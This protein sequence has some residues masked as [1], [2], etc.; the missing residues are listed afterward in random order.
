MADNF[1]F[2]QFLTENKLGAYSKLKEED[3]IEEAENIP[4]KIEV[5]KDGYYFAEDSLYDGE[6]YTEEELRH[7]LAHLFVKGDIWERSSEDPDVF[8]CIEG[9][10]KGEPSEGWW[11]YE[12]AKKFIKPIE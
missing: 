6:Y 8:I 10:W 3:K 11:D 5:I 4:S 1:N 9:S 2:K 7:G 12:S